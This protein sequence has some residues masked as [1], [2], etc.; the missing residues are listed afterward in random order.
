VDTHRRSGRCLSTTLCVI[1]VACGSPVT[2]VVSNPDGTPGCD[3][4]EIRDE[5]N[6]QLDVALYADST[7]LCAL[8]DA[9]LRVC[10]KIP[11]WGDPRSELA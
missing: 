10:E 6:F 11:I 9:N 1:F 5:H 2:T 7:Q 3:P 8:Q 4:C